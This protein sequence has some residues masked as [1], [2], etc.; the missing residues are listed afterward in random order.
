MVPFFPSK[1]LDLVMARLALLSHWTFFEC[2]ILWSL[3]PG[4]VLYFATLLYFLYFATA[5][6][7]HLLASRETLWLSLL[8][9]SCLLI[10][11]RLLLSFTEAIITVATQSHCPWWPI[12]SIIFKC[13]R[14]CVCQG[15]LFLGVWSLPWVKVHNWTI[16]S[17]Q[18]VFSAP[19][20]Q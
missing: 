18:R 3:K 9:F 10:T 8:A 13:L 15:F 1:T 2:Q 20:D 5:G 14:Y 17:C 7:E 16:P 12:S 6:E 11:V 4:P 19:I